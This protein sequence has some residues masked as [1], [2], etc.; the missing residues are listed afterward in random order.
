MNSTPTTEE[1]IWTILSHLSALSFGMGI[2]LP[3]VGWSDQR[4][5]SSYASFQCLQALGYQ[6]LGFTVWVLAYLLALVMVLTFVVVMS[7]QAE[8]AGKDFNPFSGPGTTTI[9]VL[10]FGLLALY[11]IVPIVA[12]IACATGK[13]FRYPFLGNRLA[14]Y[15]EYDAARTA[16][17]RAWLNED[18]ELRWVAAAGHFSI[19][20]LIWGM[21]APF[22]TWMLQGKRSLFLKFQSIQTLIF[23]A[24]TT[25][26]YGVGAMFYVFGLLFLLMAMAS[27]GVS[28]FDSLGIMTIVVFGASLLIAFALILSVPLL[29]LLGQWAG[30]RILKGEEYRYPLIGR[31]VQ[32]WLSKNSTV[33]ETPL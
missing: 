32:K 11:C 4:R 21:L 23:Q 33:E 13:D 22:T 28:N 7:F 25:V 6:S 2:V 19:L 18:H 31:L 26:L 9:F 16:E 8:Q 17:E 24:F 3:I 15:L 30:F 10:F 1:R 14:R 29:H 5:K 27:V 20:I 12:A